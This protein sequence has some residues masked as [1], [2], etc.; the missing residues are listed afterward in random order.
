MA[1]AR[2]A[3]PLV[4]QASCPQ[5]DGSRRQ[6]EPATHE[7]RDSR[8]QFMDESARR[9]NCASIIPRRHGRRTKLLNSR[10]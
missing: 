4:T 10:G 3:M 2:S 7:K 6:G 1:T 8:T 5:T 9:E